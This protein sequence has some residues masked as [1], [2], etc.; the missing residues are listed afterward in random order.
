MVTKRKPSTYH[1]PNEK[2]NKKTR[3]HRPVRR[4]VYET[5]NLDKKKIQLIERE[6]AAHELQ[7]RYCTNC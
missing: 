7:A 3:K 4:R 5:N 2:T 6:I 1:E